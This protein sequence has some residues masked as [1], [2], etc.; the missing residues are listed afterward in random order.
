MVTLLAVVM[1]AVMK[2]QLRLEGNRP[3]RFNP[4]PMGLRSMFRSQSAP[5]RRAVVPTAPT[6]KPTAW[7]KADFSFHQ[8]GEDTHL[9]SIEGGVPQAWPSFTVDFLLGCDEF[10]PLEEH[11]ARHAELHGWNNLQLDALAV[12]LPQMIERKLLITAEDIRVRCAAMVDPANLPPPVELIGFP[13]GGPRTAMLERCLTSFAANFQKHGRAP[14]LLVTDSSA[15][16][17]HR[18]AFRSQLQ[19]LRREQGLRLRYAGEEEKRRFADE[20]VRRSGVRASSVEFAL[21]DPLQAGFTCGANRN[22]LLLHEAGR[23]AVSV[24]DDVVCEISPIPP[25]EHR[26]ALFSQSDPCERHFFADRASALQATPFTD[27]NFLGAH[28]SLLGRDIGELFP[29]DLTAAE[30]DV[31]CIDDGILRRL[32]TG[33]V[34]LRTTFFGQVGDAGTPTSCYY[35]FAE[36]ET[37]ARLTENE[38]LYRAAFGSRSVVVGVKNPTVGGG[39]LA[40][41]MTIGLDHRELLPPFFP[42]LHAEDTIFGAVTWMCCTQSAVGHL[43]YALHHDSGAN[44]VIHQPRHL[45]ADQ[46]VTVF[47]FAT[48]VRTILFQCAPPAHADVAERIRSL[49]RRLSAFAAQPERDF[50]EAFRRIVIEME[51]SKLTCLEDRLREERSAPDYWRRDVEAFIAHTRE[52]LTFPDFDIPFDLKPQ[53]SPEANRRL[54]QQLL[55]NYGAL[56][57]DWPEI[58]KAARELRESGFIYSTAV[59]AE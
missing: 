27:V 55:A 30:I 35:F 15:D 28:E 3:A 39:L 6:E 43:P 59:S 32:A 46:R 19:R 47:E 54:M 29:P 41:G 45:T 33:P 56:L 17:E 52:A 12:W 18:A 44:K 9:V 42:V 13:T 36:G 2:R 22:A 7:R 21:F 25:G 11:I 10:R 53:R 14:E 58:V 49:G 16:P 51:G 1:G 8:A 20:L 40:P 23:M 48:I 37:L 57:E 5:P 38:A 31:S 50:L 34:R 24:D 4:R 26:V